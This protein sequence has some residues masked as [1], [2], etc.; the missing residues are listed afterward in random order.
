M[1]PLSGRESVMIQKFDPAKLEKD[2]SGIVV[3]SHGPLAAAILESAAVIMG[4]E[5]PN[6]AA[7]CLEAE[8]EPSEFGEKLIEIMQSFESGCLV[9]TDIIGG[10]P[11]NQLVMQARK[12]H[13]VPAAITGVSLTMILVAAS[14]R[15]PG[16][17]EDEMLE[18]IMK[19]NLDGMIN[20]KERFQA[21][22]K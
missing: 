18:M 7:L 21:M 3:V 11:Y 2:L 22:S 13:I 14:L 19:E 17:E 20:V 15:Q 6:S 10:T 5:V 9:F 1:Q 4:K 12:N 16:M 8:D